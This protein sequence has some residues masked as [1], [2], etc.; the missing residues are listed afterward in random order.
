MSQLCPKMSQLKD[1]KSENVTTSKVVRK[2]HNFCPKMSQL[3]PKMS[4]LLNLAQS[5]KMSQLC[6]KMSQLCPKMTQLRVRKCHNFFLSENVTTSRLVII[7][8]K[9]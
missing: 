5:P 6:P 7:I 1:P 4:Q 8:L 2:C 9:N 3:C